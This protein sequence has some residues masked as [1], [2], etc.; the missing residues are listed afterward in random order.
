V[1]QVDLAMCDLLRTLLGYSRVETFC[2]T[3]ESADATAILARLE[4]QQPR[5]VVWNL[6]QP[7]ATDRVRARAVQERLPYPVI[8]VAADPEAAGAALD[9][10]TAAT[11]LPLTRDVSN[12]AQLSTTIA[13]TLPQET[14]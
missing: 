13:A 5:L 4:P 12:L 14:D 11:L 6:V 7:Y 9:A 3:D 2:L 1:V 8:F 10:Q